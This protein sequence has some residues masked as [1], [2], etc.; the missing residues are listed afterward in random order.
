M[1]RKEKYQNQLISLNQN[2]HI[3]Y[4]LNFLTFFF[5]SSFRLKYYYN[6]INYLKLFKIFSK[7]LGFSIRSQ[8]LLKTIMLP[9]FFF[10]K[11]FRNYGSYNLNKFT[12]NKNVYLDSNLQYFLSKN[13][14][15]Q[16]YTFKKFVVNN[17]NLVIMHDSHQISKSNLFV[18]YNNR[19]IKY[20]DINFNWDMYTY[21]EFLNLLALLIFANSLIAYKIY[22]NIVY[23]N[24]N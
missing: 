19:I 2:I 8:Y 24:I 15:F 16:N 9:N 7:I 21:L 5:I 13:N 20:D 4:Y 18:F 12:L 11:L 14:K 6:Y 10:L 22:L 17:K 3:K 23:K 1:K